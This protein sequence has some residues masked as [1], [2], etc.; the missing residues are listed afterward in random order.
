[1][2][3]LYVQSLTKLALN[4]TQIQ[5]RYLFRQLILLVEFYKSGKLK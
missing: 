1:M 2:S 5:S 3:K 4:R